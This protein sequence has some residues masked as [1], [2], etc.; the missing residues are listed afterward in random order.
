[1]EYILNEFSLDGQFEDTDEFV[2]SLY[3][4]TLPVLKKLD[5][6]KINLLKSCNIYDSM[7]T[8]NNNLQAILQDRSYSEIRAIKSLLVK[9]FLDDPY[10]DNESKC[11]VES[12]YECEFTEEINNHCIA[13]AL[14]RDTALVSFE[15]DKFKFSEIKVKKDGVINNVSNIYDKESMLSQLLNSEFINYNELLCNKYDN[16][17]TFC[18]I[19]NKDYFEEFIS[20][21]SLSSDDV[22]H[23][24]KVIEDFMYKYNNSLD[25]G[26]LSKTIENY[27]EFRMSLSNNRQIRIF[28]IMEGRNFIFLNCLLK[29]QQATPEYAKDK[30]RNL[31]KEYSVNK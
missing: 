20:D 17:I 10:W 8:P 13:E 9:L 23:I 5:E 7:I 30:A 15:H 27:Y 2:D 25:L 18:V 29:K 11:I 12:K 6:K 16:I 26:R 14:E 21:N 4:N 1:M 31:I 3:K 19:N 22:K 28:Y 24:I